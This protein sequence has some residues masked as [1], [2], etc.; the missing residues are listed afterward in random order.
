MHFQE[1]A[2]RNFVLIL[3]FALHGFPRPVPGSRLGEALG[4]WLREPPHFGSLYRPLGETGKPRAR[5]SASGSWCGSLTRSRFEG[6]H[7]MPA[8]PPFGRAFQSLRGKACV[9]AFLR[10]WGRRGRLACRESCNYASELFHS[11]S[12]S[13]VPENLVIFVL[14]YLVNV[15]ISSGLYS[16][17][18]YFI[19]ASQTGI[20][21]WN[22]GCCIIHI[23]GPWRE[24]T[25][26]GL[27]L[28]WSVSSACS[29]LFI[30]RKMYRLSL[31][32]IFCFP[33]VRG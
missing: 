28:M 2:H 21:I 26:M 29:Y 8:L 5:F 12:F 1:A 18:L 11:L 24:F 33:S 10:E 9:G 27:G 6:N 32:T 7:L 3:S 31:Q 13:K 4:R 25:K 20:K 23:F 14:I 15:L 16:C 22:G 19:T 30:A 17:P